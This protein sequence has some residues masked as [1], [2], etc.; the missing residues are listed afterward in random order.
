MEES[1]PS[2]I[3]P[4]QVTQ[5]IFPGETVLVLA[6]D[7]DDAPVTISAMFPPWRIVVVWRRYGGVSAVAH[8]TQTGRGHLLGEWQGLAGALLAKLC[9]Q[10][11]RM[12][13]RRPARW[14]GPDVRRRGAQH[15]R[16]SQNG[17]RDE[18]PFHSC[19]HHRARHIRARQCARQQF[20]GLCARCFNFAGRFTF[21]G[22]GTTETPNTNRSRV[23]PARNALLGI[24]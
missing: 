9:A 22:R 8:L 19:Y 11:Q 21:T 5:N 17:E 16:H 1:K 3:Q 15:Q 23:E 20:R 2:S 7:A 24:A 13:E 12:K 14:V 6:T 4:N 18:T 10:L